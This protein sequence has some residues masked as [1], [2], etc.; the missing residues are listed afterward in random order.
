LP[1]WPWLPCATAKQRFQRLIGGVLLL[2]ML[3]DL[4]VVQQRF[5]NFNERSG[6]IMSLP[7]QRPSERTWLPHRAAC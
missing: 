5:I 1:P 7:G 4:S 2:L 6:S 3:F